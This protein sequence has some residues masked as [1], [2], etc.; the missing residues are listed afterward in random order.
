MGLMT[1]ATWDLVIGA[2]LIL[3]ALTGTLLKTLPISAAA[4]YMG[5]GFAAGPGGFNLVKLGMPADAA[6][7]ETISEVA[8]LI[9]LSR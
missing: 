9:S 1:A 7:V 3:A 2:L 4:L 5:L 6:L 8:V